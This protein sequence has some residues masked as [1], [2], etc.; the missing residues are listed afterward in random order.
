MTSTV[1]CRLKYRDTWHFEQGCQH[2]IRISTLGRYNEFAIMR[3]TKPK[4][5]ELCDE[6]RRRALVARKHAARK[7]K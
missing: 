3:R 7:G 2:F 1:Y 5:G 6:C 4:S